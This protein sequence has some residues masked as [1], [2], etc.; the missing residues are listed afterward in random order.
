M[1]NVDQVRSWEE[2]FDKVARSCFTPDRKSWPALETYWEQFWYPPMAEYTVQHPM[3][4][5]SY[6]WGFLA[7]RS[8]DPKT[9]D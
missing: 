5:T 4:A 7:A 9:K 3:A 1:G 2:T 8:H 6:A